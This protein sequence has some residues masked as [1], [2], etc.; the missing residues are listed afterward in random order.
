MYMYNACP[1]P[2]AS[3]WRRTCPFALLN[4]AQ[5][6]AAAIAA[7]AIMESLPGAHCQFN[8][9]DTFCVRDSMRMK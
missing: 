4:A 7:Q 5:R 6:Q 1:R 3:R 9:D 2:P 8:H